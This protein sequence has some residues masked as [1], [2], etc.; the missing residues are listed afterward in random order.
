[1]V[2]R[3]VG[4]RGIIQILIE[5]ASFDPEVFIESPAEARKRA[6]LIEAG[7]T[8][9]GCRIDAHE[10]LVPSNQ[11]QTWF[12]FQRVHESNHLPWTYPDL[13]AIARY[14]IGFDH[15]PEG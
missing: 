6:I 8:A 10:D 4:M 5:I 13:I 3:V 9:C 1:M 11:T 2:H 14:E 15:C 12:K 7:L